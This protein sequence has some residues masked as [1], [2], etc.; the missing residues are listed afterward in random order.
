MTKSANS[1]T[2]DIANIADIAE[3]MEMK[4]LRELR[5]ELRKVAERTAANCGNTKWGTFPRPLRI[6][7]EVYANASRREKSLSEMVTDANC[8]T[9]AEVRFPVQVYQ[10]PRP[11]AGSD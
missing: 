3:M 4:Y 11:C 2:A 5:D 8:R 1:I 7:I 6:M 9:D 10:C